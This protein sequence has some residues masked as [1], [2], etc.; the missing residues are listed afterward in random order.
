LD[1]NKRHK[2][3]YQI[4]LPA[5]TQSTT[6]ASTLRSTRVFPPTLLHESVSWRVPSPDGSLLAV[7]AQESPASDKAGTPQQIV[8][9]WQGDKCLQKIHL[10]RNNLHGKVILDPVTFGTPQWSPDGK[11]LVYTAER[12]YPETE[13]FFSGTSSKPY[14]NKS[15]SVRGGQ[16]TLGFGRNDHWGEQYSQQSALLDLYCVSIATGQVGHIDN[17]PG[18]ATSNAED[19]SRS[20]SSSLAASTLHG[21]TLG[22]VVFAPDGQS[23][24]YTAWDAGGG[25]NMPR[26]L[27]LVYCQQRPRHI[28]TSSVAQ[29]LSRLEQTDKADTAEKDAEASE[30]ELVKDEV[31]TNLT[32]D[33]RFTLSPQFSPLDNDA[34]CHRLVFLASKTGF[35]T[36]G[37][38]LELHSMEWK[39]GGISKSSPQ[40]VIDTVHDPDKSPEAWGVV[41]GLMFPGLFL[42]SLP[43]SAFV[44]PTKLL[45]NTLWGSTEKVILVDI[46]DKTIELLQ[47]SE[48]AEASEEL[49]CVSPQGD[50]VIAS[51]QLNKRPCLW[52]VRNVAGRKETMKMIEPSPVSSTSFSVVDDDVSLDF[53]CKIHSLDKNPQLEGV[54]ADFAVQSVLLLPKT[55]KDGKL[56]PLI[57][58]PHG[59]PHSAST[60]R[61]LPSY[62]YLCSHGGYAILMT[63]YRG[64]TGYGQDYIKSLPT[65]IG[66]LD[67]ADVIAATESIRKS[68]LVDPD[69]V[70]MCGGS[71]GGFLTAHCTGQY[72]DLFKAA[73]LRN[74]VV[75]LASMITTT[76][77]PDWCYVEGIGSY[78]WSQ[79][80]PPTGEQLASMYAKSPIQ[81]VHKVQAP[82]LVALGMSDLRVPPSQG[83][84]WYHSLRSRG[85]PTKLLSYPED[86]HAIAGVATGSDHWINIK[87]WFD[88]YL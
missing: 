57:V 31:C 74:P 21:Y 66:S 10:N 49:L 85:V 32:P 26:R 13:S 27:G 79:Y 54:E 59:G 82:T 28:Y 2:Y 71:H 24:V 62:A 55:P 51:R 40:V 33:Y 23:V 6:T 12:I 29:L 42:Q 65:R 75:N 5:D 19:T 1:L 20:D 36:H 45:V 70:G 67:V 78:D 77:I 48:S 17:V 56:P 53:T 81:F 9:I 87:R 60:T 63:N 30:D 84:E 14:D 88:E 52:Q 58:V 4:Q 64:S 83:L 7:F 44:S 38:C 69:R 50:A 18:A 22:Q 41:H 35:D 34:S 46:V 68:G 15:A 11:V 76:D 8:Q 72:P 73:C 80:K 37:G 43:D 47:C 16:Y 25:N 3:V 86:D 39:K 61:Y